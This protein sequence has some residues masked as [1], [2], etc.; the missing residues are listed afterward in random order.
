M[1]GRVGTGSG[2]AAAAGALEA[3]AGGGCLEARNAMYVRAR[4][5]M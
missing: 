5:R 1:A 4:I 2:A 3:T